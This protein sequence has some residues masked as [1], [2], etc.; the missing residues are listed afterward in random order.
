MTWIQPRRPQFRLRNLFVLL[1]VCSVWAAN[2]RYQAR[3]AADEQNALHALAQGGA[4]VLSSQNGHYPDWC[5]CVLGPS[6]HNAGYH[7]VLPTARLDD[8]TAHR[9]E[10]IPHL[11]D[12]S[13]GVPVDESE[14][15]ELTDRHPALRTV[16]L[17]GLLRNEPR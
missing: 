7:I 10:Q 16:F 15:M 14:V 12:V 2:Y 1:T 8:G 17:H 13:I 5:R 9:L 6:F 3:R 11:M 4:R